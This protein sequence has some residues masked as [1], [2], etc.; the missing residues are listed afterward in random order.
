MRPKFASAAPYGGPW[1][2]GQVEVCDTAVERPANDG[3]LGWERS[4]VAEVL[5]EA[6][7]ESR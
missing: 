4:V 2:F 1:L 7:R 3:P 6:E 5:P